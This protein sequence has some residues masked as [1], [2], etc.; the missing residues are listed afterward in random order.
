V[1]AISEA[2]GQALF[3]PAD[4]SQSADVAELMQAAVERFGQ[5]DIA[6]CNAA[7]QL[8]GQDAVAHELTEAVWDRVMA[9]NLRGA[10]LCAKYALPPM[11]AQGG[12]SII[13]AASPTGL[14][15][16]APDYTA[17]SASKG[18]VVALTRTLAAA[19]GAHN[20]RVNALVPGPM[21]TPLIASLIADEAVRRKIEASTMF[22]R[23][24]RADEIAGLVVFLASDEASYCT[25]GLYMA[26]GGATAL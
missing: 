12:G 6:F 20:I 7:I 18:G 15:G 26:D 21:D 11:L 19:Y 10:W 24:G 25:G 5:L 4:V 3:V 16:R 9:V 1:Q 14:S 23:L 13:F 8:H 22:G 2:G 17:Y